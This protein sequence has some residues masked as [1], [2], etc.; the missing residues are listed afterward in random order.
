MSKKNSGVLSPAQRRE[1]NQEKFSE[2]DVTQVH[3]DVHLTNFALAIWNKAED[4]IANRIFP[5][6]PVSIP[7]GEIMNFGV[8]GMSIVDTKKGTYSELNKARFKIKESERFLLEDHG[9]WDDVFASEYKRFG[10]GK[11]K[12]QLDEIK[13]KNILQLMMLAKE[14]QALRSFSADVINNY[15][16]LANSAKWNNTGSDPIADIRNL[17][18]SVEDAS[19]Q[20]PNALLIAPDVINKLCDNAQMRARIT[21]IVTSVGEGTVIDILKKEFNINEI[22]I[23]RAKTYDENSKEFEKLFFN[24]MAALVIDTSTD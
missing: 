15:T 20:K 24:K 10:N 7:T 18:T 9:L 23:P 4:F 5:N 14:Y 8:Q 2:F 22:L 17:I 1:A 12:T 19:G 3:D 11:L 13:S 6:L 16:V 21:G